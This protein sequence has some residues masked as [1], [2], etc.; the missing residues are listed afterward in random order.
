M[1]RKQ[2]IQANYDAWKKVLGSLGGEVVGAGVTGGLGY[3]IGKAISGND[4]GGVL[5][6][7]IGAIPG[8]LGGTLLGSY[9]VHNHIQKKR[10]LGPDAD[11]NF[12]NVYGLSPSATLALQGLSKAQQDDSDAD[13]AK[14][15]TQG[16]LIPFGDLIGYQKL[17]DQNLAKT[18]SIS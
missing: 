10:Q 7:S 4:S 3:L 11:A 14:L 5:G 16:A 9:L 2:Q 8:M 1:N 18:A 12:N 6:A 13:R 15:M 17:R